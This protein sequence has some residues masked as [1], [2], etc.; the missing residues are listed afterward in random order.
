VGAHLRRFH[1]L[2]QQLARSR[3]VTR[4]RGY[5]LN[6]AILG[7]ADDLEEFLVSTSRES[8][9][10]LGK[11]LRQL[12]GARCFYCSEKLSS[13]DVDHFVPFALYARD[14]VHNF[15]LA[16]PACNRSK[17]DSLAARRHLEPWL[18]RL[19][20]HADDLTQIG[21][22]VGLVTGAPVCR[23]VADWGYRNAHMAGGHAWVGSHRYEPI[24]GAYLALFAPT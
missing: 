7:E 1:P 23:Q 10:A 15:V 11:A 20:R 21:Y 8:L 22:D 9:V 12:D 5:R 3:W 17:S 14:V 2:I 19:E 24:D 6:A 4:V 13:A 18:E 16:H